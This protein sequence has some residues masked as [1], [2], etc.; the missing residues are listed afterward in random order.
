MKELDVA[1]SGLEDALAA[2]EQGYEVVL[3]REGMP[4]ARVSRAEGRVRG[5][6]GPRKAG[7][8]AGLFTVPDDFDDPIDFRDYM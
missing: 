7:S 8:A 1:Q 2:V 5:P 3:M 6:L 4:V